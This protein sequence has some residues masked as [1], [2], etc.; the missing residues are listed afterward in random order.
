M[1]KTF[2]IKAS[3]GESTLLIGEKLKNL[4]QYVP[5]DTAI[6]ITDK[7]VWDI[8]GDAFPPWPVI[9]IGTGESAK[10]LKTVESIY[11]QLLAL[12]ADRSS[13]IVGVGG[14]IVCDVAGFAAST[15]MRGIDFGFVTTTLLSQVDAGVGGKNGVNYQGYKNI[16]GVFNQPEFVICDIDLLKSLPEKEILSGLGEVVKHAVIADMDLFSFMEANTQGVLDLENRLVERL[17]HDSIVIK[18]DIVNRDEKE[19]GVRRKLNFGHTFGH[20]FEKITG[21]TH[22]EA[23]SAGMMVAAAL[24]EKRGLLSRTEVDRMERLLRELNLPT[25][26]STDRAAVVD[27]LKKDKKRSGDMINFVLLEG[28]GRAVVETITIADLVLETENI[29]GSSPD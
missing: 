19:G 10:T 24:S 23:V 26:F 13:F 20:S 14:G 27:G 12:E 28:L 1:M 5:T 4:K 11:G 7:A 2:K 15:Y 17:V 16:V 21:V 29:L 18:S 8:Y 22:G 9:Q 6:I 25:T 3:T